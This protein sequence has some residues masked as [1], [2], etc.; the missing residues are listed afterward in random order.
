LKPRATAVDLRRV[1]RSE[2]L[3]LLLLRGPLNRVLLGEL[4]GLSGACVTTVVGDLLAEGLIVQ[5]GTEGSDGGRPRV[6]VTINPAFGTLIGVDVAEK[7]ATVAAYDLTTRE[8]AREELRLDPAR[9]SVPDVVAAIAAAV[10]RMGGELPAP[11]LGVGVG[12]PGV[13]APAPDGRVHAPNIGWRDVPLGPLLADAVGLPVYVDNCVKALGQAEMWFGAGRGSEET[14]VV[15]LGTGV[16]AALFSRGNLLRGA[17]NAAGEWGHTSIVAGGRPCRCGAR[18]CIEAYLGGRALVE[19]WAEA[20]GRLRLPRRY[21]EVRWVR[22]LLAA[23]PS[24]RAA[25]GVVARAGE[26]L[27]TGIANLVNLLNPDRVVI[28]GWVGGLLGPSLLGPVRATVDRQALAFAAERVS[29]ELGRLGPGAVALGASTLVLAELVD[30]GG[31]RPDRRR[32]RAP[33]GPA[34]VAALP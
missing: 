10:D 6:R 20:D 31:R 8:L 27:G 11:A 7:V 28:A 19:Q 3:R 29:V 33:A 18:G 26:Y 22:R 23:A 9:R 34:P 12:V 21:D 13:V 24:D 25:A 5:A 16:S 15:L 17:A 2:V 30:H 1:N 4:T 14:A 32:R